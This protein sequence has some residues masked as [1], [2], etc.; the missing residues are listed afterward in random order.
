VLGPIDL[1]EFWYLDRYRKLSKTQS[2][3]LDLASNLNAPPKEYIIWLD[4]LFTSKRLLLELAAVGIG[5][6][7]TVRTLETPREH[8]E[9]VTG[10]TETIELLAGT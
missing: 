9:E 7:S 10:S 8:L 4:N 1:D 5:A 2:V 6:A 3:V